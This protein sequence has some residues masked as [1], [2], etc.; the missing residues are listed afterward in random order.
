MSKQEFLNN[1]GDAMTLRGLVIFSDFAMTERTYLQPQRDSISVEFVYGRSSENLNG[2]RVARGIV[3]E[4][5]P[6]FEI[7]LLKVKAVVDMLE[8][9]NPPN[10]SPLK[11][12]KQ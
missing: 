6:N 8:R 7:L 4:I 10:G 12:V 3:A 2:N 1:L 9:D 11:A 5:A